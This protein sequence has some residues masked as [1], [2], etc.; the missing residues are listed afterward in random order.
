MEEIIFLCHTLLYF[1]PFNTLFSYDA[2]RRR[3]ADPKDETALLKN[4]EF[5]Y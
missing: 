2:A 4:R 1:L 3:A 5:S